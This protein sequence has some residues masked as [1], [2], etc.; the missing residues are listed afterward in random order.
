MLRFQWLPDR[1]ESP[2]HFFSCQEKKEIVTAIEALEKKTSAELRVHIG[3]HNKGISVFDQAKR[4]FEN[5]GM[6]ATR[7]KNGVLIF[8]CSNRHEFAILGDSGI[9]QKVPQGFWQL[10]SE[11]MAEYF[12]QGRLAEGVCMG[13]ALA[14]EEL[15][16]YFPVRPDGRN[17]LPNAVSHSE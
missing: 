10:I 16:T 11:K 8:I 14:G 13:I 5:L 12:H 4:E 3:V 15:Q 1:D 9:D 6:T 7:E 2:K 17:E